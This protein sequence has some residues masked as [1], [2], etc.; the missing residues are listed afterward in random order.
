MLVDFSKLFGSSLFAKLLSLLL[1][2]IITRI[3]NPN[4]YGEAAV[5]TSWI[6]IIGSVISFRFF[7]A[8]PT[9]KSRRV[10]EVIC[11]TSFI[12][13]ISNASILLVLLIFYGLFLDS[14]V[15]NLFNS[16]LI[17]IGVIVYS[18]NELISICLVRFK[19]F[20]RLSLSQIVQSLLG[21]FFKVSFGF[22][23]S[24]VWPLVVGQVLQQSGNILLG[25]HYLLSLVRARSSLKLKFKVL[26]KYI[27]Y[28]IYR[29]PSRLLL[30]LSQHMTILILASYFDQQYIGQLSLVL[31]TVA[32]PVNL[33][34]QNLRKLYYSKIGLLSN[35]LISIRLITNKIVIL[36]ALISIFPSVILYFFSVELYTFVFGVEWELAGVIAKYFSISIVF[37]FISMTIIDIFNVLNKLKFYLFFNMVRFIFVSLVILLSINLNLDFKTVIISYVCSLTIC[38]I[39][40]IITSYYYIY[41]SINV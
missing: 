31:T 9:I 35:D 7:D 8:I 21:N 29:M 13:I 27:E 26:K 6:L 41:R 3:Y 5:I 28:P 1:I 19:E 30:V 20:N 38:M 40:Q 23:I 37:T 14:E 33:I 36:S 4:D 34:A 12:I 39:M 32:I 18:L 2:P 16:T 25:K 24:N 17:F 22:I 15:I 11:Q 10:I